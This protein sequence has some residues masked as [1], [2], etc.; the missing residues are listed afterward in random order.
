M[1]YIFYC[2]YNSQYLDGKNKANQTP[3]INAL[4]LMIVG[5]C[6]WGLIFMKILYFY[7]YKI[8]VP[9]SS[10]SGAFV[11]A[12]IMIFV[13]YFLFINNNRYQ[14]IYEKY[15]SDDANKKKIEKLIGVV[16]IFLPTIAFMLIALIWHNKI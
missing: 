10:L 4:G 13:H 7:I 14:M 2:I 5:S 15:K 3:W 1:D 11:I 9:K 8:N 12:I 6:S 16:Y